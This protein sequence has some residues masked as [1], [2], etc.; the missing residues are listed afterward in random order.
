MGVQLSKEGAAMSASA[1]PASAG[2]A[3]HPA[4]AVVLRHFSQR[5]YPSPDD[6]HQCRAQ[7]PPRPPSM[8]VHHVHLFVLAP[9]PDLTHL[10]ASDRCVDENPKTSLS[11][12]V[13]NIV[14]RARQKFIFDNRLAIGGGSSLALALSYPLPVHTIRCQCVAKLR[15]AASGT[16]LEHAQITSRRR[17]NRRSSRLCNS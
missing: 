12:D 4:A 11:R 5:L 17:C 7:R 2:P 9:C 16:K 10:T 3:I 6:A 1:I 14:S 8:I 15:E 13:D